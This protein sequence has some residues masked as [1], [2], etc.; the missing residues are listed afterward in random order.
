ML[1]RYHVRWP[2]ELDLR[3]IAAS[4]GGVVGAASAAMRRKAQKANARQGIAAPPLRA[5]ARIAAEAAPTG[6][7]DTNK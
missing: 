2:V 3:S 6:L 7:A 5:T 4:R 1:Q